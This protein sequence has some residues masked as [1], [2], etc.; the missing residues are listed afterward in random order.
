M[1]I[2][3]TTQPTYGSGSPPGKMMGEDPTNGRVTGGEDE[4]PM[5]DMTAE[6]PLSIIGN[7]EVSPGDVVR[8]EVVAVNHDNQSLT[9]A[10]AKAPKMTNGRKMSATD[11]LANDITKPMGPK[12]GD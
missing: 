4:Q 2:E 12:D 6:L 1:A 9:V 11:E 7:Q 3:R 5:E 10:Y 8:L